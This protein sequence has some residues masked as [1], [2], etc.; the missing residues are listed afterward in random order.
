VLVKHFAHLGA[1]EMDGRHDDVTGRLLLE[2]DD[3]LAEVGVDHLDAA[4]LQVG[5]QVA[6]LGEHRLALHQS[7][8][9]VAL[10]DAVDDAVVFLG[11]SRP[12]HLDAVRFGV[13]AELLQVLA[14]TREGVIL[15]P[16]GGLAQ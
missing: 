13:R 9:A 3:A 5:I 12:M 15:D 2:L 7:T 16:G 14:E 6:F 8:G 10:E 1:L 4:R 11:I